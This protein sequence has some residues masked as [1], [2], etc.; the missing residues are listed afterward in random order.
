MI[1]LGAA[2]APPAAAA[3]FGYATLNKIQQRHV[4]GLLAANLNGDDTAGRARTAAPLA[5]H[6]AAP[7][8]CSGHVG[9][10]VKVNQNCLN[11]TD[12]DLAGRRSE[13]R[14][15]GKE[16]SVTCRSRWSPYH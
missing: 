4:S 1:T 10:N 15:V 13:E 9:D 2:A 6:R 11:I 14:R 12:A 3:L 8:A 5:V 16:C 7:A